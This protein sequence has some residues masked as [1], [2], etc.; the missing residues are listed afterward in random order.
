MRSLRF[1]AV[2]SAKGGCDGMSE[3]R[4]WGVGTPRTMRV[5]WA[6]H[7]LGMPYDIERI[8]PRSPTARSDDYAGLNATGKVPTL[9]DGDFVLAESGAI[10]NHLLRAYGEPV[11]LKPPA[12]P[13]QQA[14][15]E[16]WC[17]FA[18]MEL[19]A[20]T[21]YVIRRHHDL[22]EIFGEATTAISA[23]RSYW[24]RAL[25]A[26]EQ[27]FGQGP[28]VLGR[29]FSGADILLVTCLDCAVRR[30]VE[31]PAPLL[32]YLDRMRSRDAYRAAF[33]INTPTASTTAVRV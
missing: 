13:L 18:L 4:V 17:F 29:A 26:A 30:Q 16:E 24:A 33:A 22:H 8:L 21:E 12:S 10:V 23:A 15:Y 6:L 28:F 25:K 32:A 14:R 2:T 9:V 3:I 11:G 27:R 19:D 20:T 5:H 1:G 31:V 7:E